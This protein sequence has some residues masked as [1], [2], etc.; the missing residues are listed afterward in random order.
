MSG[1]LIRYRLVKDILKLWGYLTSR[2]KTQFKG[3]FALML[4]AAL[5]EMV[6]MGAIFP[7]LGVIT[8][9]DAVF[10]HP[11]MQPINNFFEISTSANLRLIVTSLFIVVVILAGLIRVFLIF[12]STRLLFSAGVD[13]SLMTYNSALH[14]PYIEHVKINSSELI[15]SVFNKSGDVVYGIM[16]PTATLV[17]SIIIVVGVVSILVTINPVVMLISFLVFSIIYGAIIWFNSKKIKQNSK[18]ISSES[19]RAIKYLQ[20]GI[21][22]I[23]DVLMSNSQAFYYSKYQDT[24][25]SMRYAQGSNSI[26]GASPRYI[27]ETIGIVFI[28]LLAYILTSNEGS[29]STAI[30]TLGV[31][32]VGAQRLLPT[33]QQCYLSVSSIKGSEY[34]FRDV[35]SVLQ[36]NNRDVDIGT[37]G[38]V[39]NEKI[40]I[41][42][43]GFKYN[44]DSK[45][46]LQNITLT[47]NKGDCVGI[48]GETG[49]GKS[50]LIDI[51]MGLL[52]PSEGTILVDNQA[53]DKSN[54]INWRKSVSHVPQLIYLA[55]TTIEKN[56]AFGKEEEDI[57][58][59]RVMHAASLAQ[60]DGVISDL[61]DRYKTII[62]EN[63]ISLS[64]GQRQRIGIAR[65]LFA[66]TDVIV[67]D[68]A[69][70][71]LDY[72]TEHKVMDSISQM[73][74]TKT[75]II[76]AHRTETLKNCNKIV[77]LKN[78]RISQ[79]GKYSDFY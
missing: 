5:A 49:S 13:I 72:D 58:I 46:V 15:N 8:N 21:G 77:K 61:P 50:T 30:P 10:I 24:I 14:M 68:E 2:R 42:N 16:M 35:L 20:E 29:V 64:G 41:D 37:Q 47:I 51:L 6:S 32:A 11:L 57:D 71:A 66:N 3:L 26:I 55:D 52:S 31:L 12:I 34:A 67:L 25:K 39:F 43:V 33:L 63:G 18:L 7:F 79:I 45:F 28:A 73:D 19:T 27:I 23:R 36:D 48:V 78:G 60:I 74:G 76:I 44:T 69:T 59:S 22:G 1:M 53:L 65:S 9:P 75:I 62:G 70:S 17:S 38:V 54:L 4:I 56:I 40:E